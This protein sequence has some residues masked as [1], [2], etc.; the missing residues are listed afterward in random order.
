MSTCF[1]GFKRLLKT[2]VCFLLLFLC[3]SFQ[4]KNEISE[5]TIK[6]LFIYNF[7]KYV[8]WP[9]EKDHGHIIIGFYGHS[10]IIDEL[11]KVC[12]NKKIKDREVE[13]RQANDV[14]EAENCDIFFI[15]R[16][17]SGD[18]TYLN[19]QLQGKAV[20]IVTEEKGFGQKGAAINIIE[21]DDKIRFELNE[22]SIKRAGLK[23]SSQLIAL[24][25]K[26]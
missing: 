20:L 2:T 15:P 14:Y 23:I 10:P 16:G 12:V 21:K 1:G 5:S 24:A 13:I 4:G 22:A 3:A 7:T 26:L 17:E 19:E 11:K 6:A 25:I 18:F 9:V 8:E